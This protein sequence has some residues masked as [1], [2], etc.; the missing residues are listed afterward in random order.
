[1]NDSCGTG[2][3]VIHDLVRYRL[4]YRFVFDRNHWLELTE[5]EELLQLAYDVG[6]FAV[7]DEHPVVRGR[8]RRSREPG[9]NRGRQ[10]HRRGPVA[11]PSAVASI[12][13]RGGEILRSVIHRSF[14]R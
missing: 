2:A 14:A 5:A 9:I 10:C 7:G 8:S 11:R 13:T 3:H 12:P 4:A 1:M 6:V